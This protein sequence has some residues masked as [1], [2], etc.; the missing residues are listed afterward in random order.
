MATLD[1]HETTVTVV[2]PTIGATRLGRIVGTLAG[3]RLPGD[4]LHVIGRTMAAASIPLSLCVFF[5]QVLPFVARRYRVTDRR[6]V[7]QR[8]LSCVDERAVGLREFDAV[9]VDVL[10]GQS[11]LRAGDVVFRNA[12]QEVLR[13]AGVPSPEAFRV[14]CRDVQ[15]AL[16]HM[17]VVG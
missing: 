14:L 7:I 16:A 9:E 12:G 10:P 15:Q 6:I 13:L 1:Q 4:P 11:W 17:P 5:W 3:L 8:G 2:W